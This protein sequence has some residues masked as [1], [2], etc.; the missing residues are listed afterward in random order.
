[1]PLELPDRQALEIKPCYPEVPR[2]PKCGWVGFVYF[3]QLLREAL[4]GGTGGPTKSRERKRGRGGKTS[5]P[6]VR[7]VAL[8]RDHQD[9]ASVSPCFLQDRLE[10]Q[11][12]EWVAQTSSVV[13]HGSTVWPP[14]AQQGIFTA[15]LGLRPSELLGKHF[16][17][18]QP[19]N[20]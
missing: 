20:C 9:L 2:L 5:R 14:L 13:R 10:E 19:E 3:S 16:L 17:S 12:R 7:M 11:Q 1:M 8:P 18:L 15:D 6:L 4:S